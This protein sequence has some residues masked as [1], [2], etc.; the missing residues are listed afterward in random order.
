[1]IAALLLPVLGITMPPVELYARRLILVRAPGASDAAVLSTHI[2]KQH[3]ADVR[4]IMASSA[5]SAIGLMD[6]LVDLINPNKLGV[7]KTAQSEALREIE[8]SESVDDAGWRV[9]EARDYIL[10]G[11]ADGAASLIIS[12]PNIIELM[13]L[14]A[15][16]DLE[17]D[18]DEFKLGVTSVPA[19]SVLDFGPGSLPWSVAAQQPVIQPPWNVED[20]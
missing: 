15:S 12:H 13:L 6:T 20:A 3:G 8:A 10:R 16:E 5:E 7:L 17:T 18:V 4:Y 14:R 11:T 2:E 9:L 1:M 19:V